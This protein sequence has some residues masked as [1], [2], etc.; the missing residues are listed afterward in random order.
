MITELYNAFKH[1]KFTESNHTYVN[2]LTGEEF[3]SVTTLLKKLK[4]EFDSKYWSLYTALKRNG[5]AIQ[6]RYPNIR[7]ENSTLSVEDIEALNLELNPSVDDI[8]E[9]WAISAI[10]G[11]TLGTF[12]HN[13]MEYNILRKDI[14]QDVPAFVFNLKS[15]MAIKYLKNRNIL[16]E[17]ADNFYTEFISKY[18]P[19]TTEFVIGDEDL[20]IAGTFDL[21]A[22]NN[23]TNEIEL[24]DYKTDKEIK[25]HS[26]YN[27]KLNVFNIDDCEF[28]KYSLQLS[29]YKYLLEKN[30]NLKI[31]TCKIAHFSYLK[32]SVEVIEI[33]DLSDLVKEFFE[34]NENKSIYF[35]HKTINKRKR[36][37]R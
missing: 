10:S 31:S 9:E 26:E 34:N 27:K 4:P 8:K 3:I 22:L 36:T 33:L 14:E 23:E 32:E 35:G 21:L 19:I 37:R 11:Q 20:K 17:M 13:R 18:T 24:W 7:I 1:I 2:L 30:T 28:N 29:I 16:K 25:F 15:Y 5:H 6:P 12:L